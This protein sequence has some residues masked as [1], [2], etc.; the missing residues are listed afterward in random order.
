[1]RYL[2]GI[3]L[4]PLTCRGCGVRNGY[5]VNGAIGW[6]TEREGAGNRDGT[7]YLFGQSV[8]VC[9]MGFVSIDRHDTKL[10]LCRPEPKG[11]SAI[12]LS[13]SSLLALCCS[14][15][16]YG[17]LVGLLFWLWWRGKGGG[18]YP[19]ISHSGGERSDIIQL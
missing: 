6:N 14:C 10:C 18:M 2:W 5:A 12:S 4:N 11:R 9:Q 17:D 16:A 15:F 13:P 1:M 8:D 7:T 19:L 3:V